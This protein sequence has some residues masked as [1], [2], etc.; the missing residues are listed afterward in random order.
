MN[1]LFRLVV[2][3]ALSL[4]LAA[5]GGGGAAPADSPEIA[6]IE[7]IEAAWNAED[8][9]K[10]MS[11]YTDD[12]VSS[13]SLGK[14]TGK[15]AIRTEWEKWINVFTMDCRNYSQNGNTLT[16]EC[17]L[18]AREGTNT[19]LEYY[20]TVIENGKIKSEILTG[21]NLNP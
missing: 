1:T 8:L 4:S 7:G 16:Y 19:T 5:C 17:F 9:D 10:V 13:N 6:V 2:L 15:D 14:Y 12:A 20:E 3:S 18:E 11:Y 21:Q